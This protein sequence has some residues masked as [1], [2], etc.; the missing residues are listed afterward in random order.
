MP[1]KYRER[2]L[3]EV[4]AQAECAAQNGG[5]CLTVSSK[6]MI[7]LLNSHEALAR[8]ACGDPQFF[9]P[10]E[11]SQ[12]KTHRDYVLRQREERRLGKP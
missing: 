5:R 6:W 8:L 11:V 10:L 9:D 7:M 4:R 3:N 1:R 12:A 2:T